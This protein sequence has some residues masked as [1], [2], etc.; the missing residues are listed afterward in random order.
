MDVCLFTAYYAH[1]Y[2]DQGAAHSFLKTQTPDLCYF[3]DNMQAAQCVPRSGELSLSAPFLDYLQYV[4]PA[5]AGFAQGIVAATCEAAVHGEPG[6]VF[7]RGY[8]PFEFEL[9]GRS[10][11]RGASSFSAWKA[12]RIHEAY[13]VLN[14]QQRKQADEIASTIGW[15]QFL[16]NP[17]DYRLLREDYQIKLLA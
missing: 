15:Q 4:G 13:Q 2:R 14:A 5:G 17:P 9:G 16:H 6:K 7:H 1:Q 3:L 10:F 11:R 12:Q 8:E